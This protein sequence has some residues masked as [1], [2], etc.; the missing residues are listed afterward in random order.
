M[1]TCKDVAYLASKALDSPITWRQRWGMRLHLLV[2]RLCRRYVQNL[3]FLNRALRRTS[4]GNQPCFSTQQKLSEQAREKIQR[5]LQDKDP[6]VN[7]ADD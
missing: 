4:N 2:C 7:R 5:A 3:D 1:L 6:S